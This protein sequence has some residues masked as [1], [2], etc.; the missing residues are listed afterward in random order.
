MSANAPGSVGNWNQTVTLL[1]P[2]RQDAMKENAGST[3][4][5]VSSL[6]KNAPQFGVCG[7][8]A[9]AVGFKRCGA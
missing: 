5:A 8:R 3:A 4:K 9:D 1:G 6:S 2:N 7:G